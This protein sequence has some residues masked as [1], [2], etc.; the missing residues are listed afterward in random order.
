MK[1]ISSHSE[2]L[3]LRD[4]FAL[5]RLSS[6][7][8]ILSKSKYFVMS[9]DSKMFLSRKQ[10]WCWLKLLKQ[11]APERGELENRCITS[12]CFLKARILGLAWKLL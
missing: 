11:S 1:K 2:A 6:R 5:G 12:R 4:P 9:D 8:V 3:R 10:W 7:T